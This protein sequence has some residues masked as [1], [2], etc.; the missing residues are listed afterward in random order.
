MN[1]NIITLD[2]GGTIFKASYTC[3]I[4][5]EFF[6]S[7]LHDIPYINELIY[8]DRCGH[9]FKHVLGYLRN[10]NYPY[11]KKYVEE[12]DYFLIDATD[13]NMY[14]P[15]QLVEECIVD[16]CYKPCYGNRNV[17]KD[18]LHLCDYY[19]RDVGYCFGKI[20][21]GEIRCSKHIMEY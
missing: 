6:N 21:V 2:V 5:C 7:L 13:V 1:D 16:G 19:I 15:N 4:K 9:V 3:L 10:D 17:C 12:L 18:H 14:D 11:P 8:I 20:N